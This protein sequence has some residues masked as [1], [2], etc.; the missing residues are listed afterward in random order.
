MPQTMVALDP[1]PILNRIEFSKYLNEN[2]RIALLHS[3]SRELRSLSE[4]NRMNAV[5]LRQDSRLRR[6]Q[7]S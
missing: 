4:S 7:I 1:N 5:K 2:E 6:E 3:I